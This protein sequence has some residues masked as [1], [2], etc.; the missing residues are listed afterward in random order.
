MTPFRVKIIGETVA[1]TALQQDIAQPSPALDSHLV[2][3]HPA[4]EQV[5]QMPE[6]QPKEPGLLEK[7]MENPRIRDAVEA[8]K[9]AIDDFFKRLRDAIEGAMPAGASDMSDVVINVLGYALTALLVFL[10][11]V[12]VYFLLTYIRR[13]LDKDNQSQSPVEFDHPSPLLINADWHQREARRLAD[14][15][16]YRDAVRQM[17]LATLCMLE[18]KRLVAFDAT[19]TDMEYLQELM[20]LPAADLPDCFKGLADQFEYIRYG[21]G[22]TDAEG[23]G[24][25]NA[26]FADFSRHAVMATGDADKGEEKSETPQ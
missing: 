24:Q 21:A 22:Q 5:R 25:Y 4:L 23:F 17:F 20:E 1:D 7:L 14:E 13:H 16:N 10:L 18:E 11:I 8:I 26:R 9:T 15:N 3:I 2:D 19:R 12:A 6:F